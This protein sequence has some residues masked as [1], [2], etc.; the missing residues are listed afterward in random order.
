MPP[1]PSTGPMY[2][3]MQSEQEIDSRVPRCGS[4]L[5]ST[6]DQS[7]TVRDRHHKVVAGLLTGRGCDWYDASGTI[8]A[9]GSSYL[10]VPPAI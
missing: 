8:I 1:V 9:R 5:C 3:T 6:I 10:V 2:F 4:P 7:Q